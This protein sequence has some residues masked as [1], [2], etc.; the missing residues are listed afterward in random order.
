MQLYYLSRNQHG[1][2]RVRFTDP[3]T[4]KLSVA[5]STHCKNRTQAAHIAEEWLRER[6]ASR[7]GCERTTLCSATVT[8]LE[9]IEEK[10]YEK[11]RICLQGT[12]RAFYTEAS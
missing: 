3:V 8:D 7:T 10:A 4:G 5:K 11:F 2:F 6:E 12:G 9:T 1:Y